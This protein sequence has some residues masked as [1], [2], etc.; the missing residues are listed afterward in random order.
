MK[1][2]PN[3]G[4]KGDLKFCPEC[5]TK[6][7]E[8]LVTQETKTRPKVC[9]ECGYEGMSVYCPE[10]GSEMRNNDSQDEIQETLVE[11]PV[12]ENNVYDENISKETYEETFNEDSS[13]SDESDGH[14]SLDQETSESVITKTVEK[15]EKKGKKKGFKKALMIGGIALGIVLLALIALGIIGSLFTDDLDHDLENMKKATINSLNYQYP[16]DWEV[17][18]DYSTADIDKCEHVKYVRYNKDDKTLMGRMY[19]YYLGD[20]IY[21][22]DPDEYFKRFNNE[23][24]SRT[25]TVGDTDVAIKEYNTSISITKD[26]E[27]VDTPATSYT[28]IFEKDYSSYFVVIEILDDYYDSTFC[29][30]IIKSI[31][32]EGYTNPRT[33]TQISAEYKGENTPGIEI[34]SGDSNVTVTVEYAE[35][36]NEEAQKWELDKAITIIEGETSTATVSC[37]GLTCE[38]EVT[39]RKPVE[40]NAKYEGSTKA[41]TKITKDDLTVTVKYDNGDKETVTDFEIDK[42]VKLKAGETS[43][44]KVKYGKLSCDVTVKCTSLSKEQYKAK[45]VSR[46]YK[47]QLRKESYD[48]FIKIHGKVLQDCGYGYYRI[49]SN[50]E[51]D[52]VYMVHAPDSD[53]VED[54]WCTVYGKTAG[55]Y[56]YETVMGAN[57]KVPQINAKYVDR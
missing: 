29:D 2:C 50:G 26:G 1:Y 40:I 36:E 51:Y 19:Y 20:D 38:L 48:K 27:Q 11:D 33:A 4:N 49:S 7:E 44:I 14:G 9:P 16:S 41:G 5:G 15:T 37:H 13:D 32:I 39:G 8:E 12:D 10:C 30:E 28:A 57:Q 22:S 45:C 43:E 46:N 55:I 34:T 56:E 6:M 54:D 52:D 17:G 35:G 18:K 47:D 31:D 42:S 23:T 53:I 25:L 21:A 3:C 24:D